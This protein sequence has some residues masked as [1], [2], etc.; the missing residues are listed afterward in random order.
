MLINILDLLRIKDWLKNLL[1]FLPVIFSN[2]LFQ[3]QHY[4]NLIYGFFIFCLAS[5]FVYIV[6]DIKDIDDDKIHPLKK[7]IKPLA[8]GKLQVFLAKKILIILI[9][10]LGLLLFLDNT[11]LNLV[12]LYI[13]LNLAYNYFLKKIPILDIL[14]I[15]L[16]YLLRVEAGSTVIDVSTSYLTFCSVFFLSTFIISIKRKKELENNILSRESLRHYNIITL[17]I[18]IYLSMF[19]S[20]SSYLFYTIFINSVLIITLPVVILVFLRYLYVTRLTTQ[21]EFPID[22]VI[23]DWKLLL[24]LGL[25][26]LIILYSFINY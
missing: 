7:N 4:L 19:A 14:V 13:I 9:F 26:L 23:Y 3:T 24:L 12:F 16:G 2:N 6:N 11:I 21:G 10:F 25:F 15:S 18:L 5:S 22:V 17:N 1:I 20:F 8:N